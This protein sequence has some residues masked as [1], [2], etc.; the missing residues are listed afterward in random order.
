MLG[1]KNHTV[2]LRVMPHWGLGSPLPGPPPITLIPLIGQTP[3]AQGWPKG[4]IVPHPHGCLGLHANWLAPL[5][6]THAKPQLC[7]HGQSGLQPQPGA[8]PPTPPNQAWLWGEGG[9]QGVWATPPCH[10]MTMPTQ[11]GLGCK[12]WLAKP[13]PQSQPTGASMAS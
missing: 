2:L 11:E 12:V 1:A 6:P 5:P 8:A 9:Q 10:A 3:L 4:V 7:P 13:R